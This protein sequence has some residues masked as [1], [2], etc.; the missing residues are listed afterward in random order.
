MNVRFTCI[1]LQRLNN[2]RVLTIRSNSSYHFYITLYFREK[3]L[4]SLTISL[5]QILVAELYGFR[6]EAGLVKMSTTTFWLY[7]LINL[8]ASQI[9]FSP[10]Y[11]QIILPIPCIHWGELNEKC[12]CELHSI[13]LACSKYS[14]NIVLCY[15]LPF[16]QM[17]K[18]KHLEG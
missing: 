5:R 15:D 17:R 12:I 1:S 10:L 18:W 11:K 14:V 9:S 13:S 6:I 2:V 7:N 8:L 4:C 3:I 16:F